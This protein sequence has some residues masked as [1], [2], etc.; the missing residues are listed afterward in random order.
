MPQFNKMDKYPNLDGS[1]EVCETETSNAAQCASTKVV[2]SQWRVLPECMFGVQIKTL[3]GDYINH[4]KSK[5]SEHS[6]FKY[7]CEAKSMNYGYFTKR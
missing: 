6:D 2:L 7:S 1:F 4:N 3:N 5:Q